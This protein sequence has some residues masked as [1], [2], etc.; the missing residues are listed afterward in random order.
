MFSITLVFGT[1]LHLFHSRLGIGQ[2]GV[3]IPTPSF[4]KFISILHVAVW[5]CYCT[6]IKIQVGRVLNKE[7]DT[8]KYLTRNKKWPSVSTLASTA[9]KI[10]LYI[11]GY[12]RI[13]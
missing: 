7:R 10:V 1:K 8:R 3:C 11:Y 13:H 2:L 9:P 6:F 4:V 12:N 5:P